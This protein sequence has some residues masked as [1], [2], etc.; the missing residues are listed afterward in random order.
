MISNLKGMMKVSSIL[1]CLNACVVDSCFSGG[2]QSIQIEK[3][4]SPC[5][6]IFLQGWASMIK[7]QLWRY[8][9]FTVC[10]SSSQLSCLQAA[11]DKGWAEER[12]QDKK[13][14]SHSLLLGKGALSIA[15]P[16]IVLMSELLFIVPTRHHV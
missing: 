12:V 15:M 1:F 3:Q 13:P 7:W 14:K 2:N 5:Q 8:K 10:R 11:A 6:D 9:P 4:G 16:S